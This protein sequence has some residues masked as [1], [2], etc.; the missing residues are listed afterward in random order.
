[1][2]L[3]LFLFTLLFLAMTPVSLKG[4]LIDLER[5]LA[6]DISGSIDEE[7]ALEPP[8]LSSLKS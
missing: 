7:E 3:I 4:I 8:L 5:V 2:V 1:M 6:A